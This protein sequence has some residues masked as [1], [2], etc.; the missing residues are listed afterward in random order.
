M[1]NALE[2]T[3]A[4]FEAEVLQ[5]EKPVLVDF[6]ATWCQPCLQMAPI[7]DQVAAERTDS[8]KVVK[9]DLDKNPA[10]QQ[11]FGITSIPT[12]MVFREG[13]L[14]H[15]VVGGRPKALLEKEIDSALA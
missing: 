8:L 6:W 10:L 12:F 15:S 1:S 2:V 13:E 11:R 4:T 7:V 5:S 9:V 14:V 3:D